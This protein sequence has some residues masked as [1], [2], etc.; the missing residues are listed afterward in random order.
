[1]KQQPKPKPLTFF[2][3]YPQDW[4][5][6]DKDAI[7]L[8]KEISEKIY[9][10]SDRIEDAAF[11]ENGVNLTLST[12]GPAPQGLEKSVTELITRL[13]RNLRMTA[14]DILDGHDG[15]LAAG[16][17]DP[18]EYLASTGQVVMSLP[19]VPIFRGE[20]LR[21]HNGID[22]FLRRYALDLGCR[23]EKYPTTLSTLSLLKSG[24][25]QGFPQHAL[26]VG[27]IHHDM[28]SLQAIARDP[29]KYNNVQ[30][31]DTLVSNH[32][33]ILAPTVCGHCFE[34][35]KGQTLAEKNLLVTATAHCHR[36]EGKNHNSLERLQTYT[37]REIVFFGDTDFVRY[38]QERILEDLK[39]I[40]S[41]WGLRWRVLVASDPFFVTGREQK[42]AFQ[43]AFRLKYELQVYLPHSGQWIAAASFNH[44]QDGLVKSYELKPAGDLG[45]PLQSGCFGLGLERLAYAL[46][47]QKGIDIQNWPAALI[48]DL[49][50]GA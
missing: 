14:H 20:F 47:A 11:G 21:V 49:N 28:D 48:N 16:E 3:A 29:D 40:F 18:Y 9:Y 27:A 25:L 32:G 15:M 37:M 19:G 45:A 34:A 12:P 7:E 6:E 38:W 33:Q 43:T 41:E 24:Y 4:P 17:G 44:H 23:E 30:S 46:Y 2:V 42:R 50:L 31:V 10:L 13:V 5:R 39:R 35:L 22:M 26:L 8:R 1:M 36:H